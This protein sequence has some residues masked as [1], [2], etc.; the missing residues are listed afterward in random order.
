MSGRAGNGSGRSVG[1][2][3]PIPRARSARA[4]RLCGSYWIQFASAITGSNR[5]GVWS[6]DTIGTNGMPS[7]LAQSASDRQAC[8]SR[9]SSDS[10]GTKASAA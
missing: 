3:A 7:E 6:P 10:S 4:L 1:V 9:Y 8:D 2:T 5:P